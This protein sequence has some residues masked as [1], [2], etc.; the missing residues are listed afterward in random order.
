MR[1]SKITTKCRKKK[2]R[3][4]LGTNREFAT[5]NG[6]QAQMKCQVK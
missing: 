2:T 3:A 6:D 4:N 5:S 1:K